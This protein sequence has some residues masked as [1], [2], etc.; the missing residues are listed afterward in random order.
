MKM[1]F[2]PSITLLILTGIL[3]VNIAWT[4]EL[5]PC[6]TSDAPAKWTEH[7]L[8]NRGAFLKNNA[9]LYVPVT[10]HI[11]GDNQGGGYLAVKSVLNA[12]CTLNEDFTS[13][14]IQFFIQGNIRFINRTE[15]YEHDSNSD[16]ARMNNE[17]GV[18]RTINSYFVSNAADAAGYATGIGGTGVV[19]AKREATSGNHTWAH[20]VGHALGLYHPF[21][22]WDGVSYDPTANAP[23]SVQGRFVEKVDGSNCEFSGDGFCDTSPDYLSDRWG[24]NNDGLSDIVQRDPDG[25]TFRSDG[26]NIMS[27]AS[28]ACV[29]RFSEEQGTAMRAH[30]QSEK[31]S[32]LRDS[33]PANDINA[34]TTNAVLP[35]RG[36]SVD[37]NAVFLQWEAI[38]GASN[39]IVEVSILPTFAGP[40]TETF[41]FNTNDG[42]L[43][44]LS[45]NRTYYWRVL[46]FNA[47]STCGKFSSSSTFKT[48]TLTDV[49]D[50]TKNTTSINIF[51]NPLPAGQILT[52]QVQ[53]QNHTN[54][55]VRLFD[56]AGKL[57]QTNNYDVLAGASTLEFYSN[58]V[59]QGIYIMQVITDSGT[60]TKRIVIQ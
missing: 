16:G 29:E 58:Q 24:C 48:T 6:A 7:Y 10:V 33:P 55:D 14:N 51:P 9:T 21:R 32:F 22:G 50:L 4:Q 59:A 17:F 43:T 12:F 36:E 11:V 30:M 18:A 2:K 5:A 47:V 53:A 60:L 25:A 42:V 57:I 46:A 39:Y 26:T 34:S 38:P 20:E 41:V 49:D 15:Y 40:L 56:L 31:S 13:A 37:V 27:Y 45:N 54:V 52:L 28:D 1:I 44:G 8:Q 19:I 35:A 23:A 3:T